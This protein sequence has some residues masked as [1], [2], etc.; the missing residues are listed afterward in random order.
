VCEAADPWLGLWIL[1]IT[2]VM[3]VM[4]D[5]FF[6][7]PMLILRVFGSSDLNAQVSWSVCGVCSACL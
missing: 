1:C 6:G 7:V 2:A 5:N 3:L 4:M